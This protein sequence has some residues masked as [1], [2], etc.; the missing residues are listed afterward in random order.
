[1]TGPTAFLATLA[2]AFSLATA[3][4]N[5]SAKFRKW[6]SDFENVAAKNGVKRSVYRRAFQ[7]ITSTDPEVL[8][9]ARYQPEFRQ[10]TWMYFDSRVNEE[11]IALGQAKRSELSGTLARIEKKYGVDRDILLAIWSMESGYGAA[12]TK[13]GG[14]RNIIRSL[15][16]LAYADKRR[17]KFARSQL[18]SAMKIVQQ[19]GISADQLQGSWAGAMGH[20]QF[21]P[22]SYEL[23]RQDFDGDGRANIWTSVPDALATAANL[24]KR[25]GWRTGQTWGYEVTVPNR[26]ADQAGKTRTTGQWAKL[27]VRRVSGRPFPSSGVRGVLKYPAGKNGPAFLMTKNFYTIKRY[28]NS[29]KYALAVGHLAD[30]IAGYG[31]FANPIPRPFRKLSFAERVE[32]QTLLAALGLYDSDIDGKIGSG[33]RGAIRKAQIKFGLNPDGFESPKFLDVLRRRS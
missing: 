17:R 4:A 14:T 2:I 31:D 26:V 3:P 7:G 24:L 27:G 32:L 9:L 1:M 18:I 15:A 20:T 16:T 21:I 29:D 28:N 5:A 6:I 8:E 13:P 30:Q 19:G 25:N 23:Y 22:T 33:T 12:L 10:K 11:S